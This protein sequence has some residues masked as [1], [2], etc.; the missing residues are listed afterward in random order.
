MANWNKIAMDNLNMTIADLRDERK[1]AEI[2]AEAERLRAEA[3]RSEGGDQI[4][5]AAVAAALDSFDGFRDSSMYGPTVAELAA[6]LTEDPDSPVTPNRVV[7]HLAKMRSEGIIDS[8]PM[9][10]STGKRGRPPVFYFI[11]DEDRFEAVL[12]GEYTAKG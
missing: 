7:Q 3:Q 6:H 5:Q 12:N 2:K 9:M 4:R 1:R 11:L 10:E 8:A